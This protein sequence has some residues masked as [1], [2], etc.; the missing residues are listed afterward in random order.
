MQLLSCHI[1]VAG[2]D[3]NIVVREFDTAVTYPELLILKSLHGAENV[4]HVADAGD[5]E[6]D[7][8]DERNRLREIYGGEIVKQVFPGDHT[9]LPEV[10]RRMRKQ[11]ASVLDDDEDKS[12]PKPVTQAPAG[13]HR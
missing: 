8:D 1:A 5:V 9:P 4:R 3:Q 7:N 11:T 10:D 2:D 12:K 13:K 6:R